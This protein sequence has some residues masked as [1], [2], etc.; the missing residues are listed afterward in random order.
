MGVRLARQGHAVFRGAAAGRVGGADSCGFVD[1]WMR[2]P[3]ITPGRAAVSV[4][5]MVASP[6]LGASGRGLFDPNQ[7]VNRKG[8]RVMATVPGTRL[9]EAQLGLAAQSGWPAVGAG[10]DNAP[11]PDPV[12]GLVDVGPAT[13]A[14]V[15]GD[16]VRAV[17]DG[18]PCPVSICLVGRRAELRMATNAA[19]EV[20]AWGARFGFVGRVDAAVSSPASTVRVWRGQVEASPWVGWPLDVFCLLDGTVPAPAVGTAPAAPYRPSG[21]HLGALLVPSRPT[22][23]AA[24]LAASATVI[25]R[26]GLSVLDGGVSVWDAFRVALVGDPVLGELT[27]EARQLRAAAV[28]VLTR[29]L[30]TEDLA[31]WTR[32][33]GQARVLAAL[34]GA[35]AVAEQLAEAVDPGDHEPL[36]V[37]ARVALDG[38]VEHVE[39]AAV[40]IA[41]QAETDGGRA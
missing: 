36:F 30:L 9:D 24:L 27:A 3:G 26:L 19:A 29:L 12:A 25:D 16:I 38:L 23:T 32:R 7:P 22:S 17:A 14:Q 33:A 5:A 1:G 11:P 6:R 18:L 15:L 31:G 13:R 28:W 4:S 10:D 2:R 39:S 40:V 37:A 35:A 20:D 8:F 41:L 34:R 21:G